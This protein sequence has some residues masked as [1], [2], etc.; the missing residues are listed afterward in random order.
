[1]VLIFISV[2]LCRYCNNRNSK[3]R[4]RRVVLA[5]YILP[6]TGPGIA[7]GSGPAHHSDSAVFTLSG[8][9]YTGHANA[10]FSSYGDA[11]PPYESLQ[12]MGDAGQHYGAGAPHYVQPTAPPAYS[13]VIRMSGAFASPKPEQASSMDHPGPLQHSSGAV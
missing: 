11:P 9:S 1:M 5:P 8:M 6:P 7:S 10:G 12:P 2:V 3:R 4:A 13:E